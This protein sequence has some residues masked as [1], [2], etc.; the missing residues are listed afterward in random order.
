VVLPG[1]LTKGHLRPLDDV[2]RINVRM[3]FDWLQGK[4]MMFPR[5]E[6]VRAI[7]R[8][9]STLDLALYLVFAKPEELP[10]LYQR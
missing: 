10:S 7:H 6:I 2:M 8:D 4:A 5:R 9:T 3:A 1:A